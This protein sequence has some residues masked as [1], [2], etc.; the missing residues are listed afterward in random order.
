[1]CHHRRTQLGALRHMR[2]VFIHALYHRC[3]APDKYPH[4]RCRYRPHDSG[5]FPATA[6]SD[7]PPAQPARYGTTGSLF[8]SG[9]GHLSA[10]VFIGY[11]IC[12]FR[13]SHGPA[14]PECSSHVLHSRHPVPALAR[15]LADDRHLSGISRSFPHC[16]RWP[17]TNYGHLPSGTL[18]GHRRRYRLYSVH[19]PATQ[20]NP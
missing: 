9:T 19:G 10:Y 12:Q 4:A 11:P 18:L 16:H 1:M 8:G 20:T 6:Y 3:P 14:I 7:S 13:D 15:P 2:P 5:H 17:D